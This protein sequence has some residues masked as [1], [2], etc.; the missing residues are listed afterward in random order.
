VQLVSFQLFR[1]LAY[2]HSLSVCHRDIKPNNILINEETGVVKICDMGS[3]K[4][5]ESGAPNVSYICS[6][7]FRAPE[8]LLGAEHYSVAIGSSLL[9]V[10]D[11]PLIFRRHLVGW[12]HHG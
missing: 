1:G 3:M 10:L 4:K 5:L 8:L 6:R 11:S 7:F 12:L 9:P 2:I